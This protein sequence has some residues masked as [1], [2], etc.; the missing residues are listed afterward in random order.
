MPAFDTRSTFKS[1]TKTFL[2]FGLATGLVKENSEF[3]PVKL[4]L[5]IDLVSYLA[6]GSGAVRYITNAKEPSLPH[7]LPIVDEIVSCLFQGH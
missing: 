3:K 6:G 2:T 1:S 4:R 5:K 7:N